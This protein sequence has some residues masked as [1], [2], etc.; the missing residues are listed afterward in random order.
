M[1]VRQVLAELRGK[2]LIGVFY[3]VGSLSIHQNDD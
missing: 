3:C 2:T 1:E